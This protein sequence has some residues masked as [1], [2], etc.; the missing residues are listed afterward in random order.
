MEPEKEWT[1]RDEANYFIREKGKVTVLSV[2][3]GFVI[4]ASIPFLQRYGPELPK[5]DV[6]MYYPSEREQQCIPPHQHELP[7]VQVIPL[8]E[9]LN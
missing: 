3:L 7:P 4:G 2:A 6:Q 9:Q 1:W 5:V 8:N